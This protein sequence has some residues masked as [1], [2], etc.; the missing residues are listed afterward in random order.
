MIAPPSLSDSEVEEVV[1]LRPGLG[2]EVSRSFSENIHG[3]NGS[4]LGIS[5]SSTSYERGG[6]HRHQPTTVNI[7]NITNINMSP[8]PRLYDFGPPILHHN[9]TCG[10]CGERYWPLLIWDHVERFHPGVRL[11]R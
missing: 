11:S 5:R 7:T 6:G 4:R 9:R 2:D 1:R 10:V 8:L 3:L